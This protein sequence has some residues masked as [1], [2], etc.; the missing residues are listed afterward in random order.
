[1]A[2]KKPSKKQSEQ[3]FGEQVIQCGFTIVPSVL[4]Q[5]Q[6]RLGISGQ[7]L[8]ILIHLLDYW[9]DPASKPWP[10]KEKIADR[11]QI[12]TKQV[13]RHMR[14]LEQAGYVRRE[15]RYNARGGQTS[16]SYDLTGLVQKMKLLGEE[17]HSASKQAD[18][19]KSGAQRP[20]HRRAKSSEGEAA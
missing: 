5:C 14:A 1:M 7:Q 15:E 8:A 12:S 3:K 10:S 16:N 20:K 13:Q 19:I 2:H 6:E 11:M 4:L 18:A 9:W 17:L